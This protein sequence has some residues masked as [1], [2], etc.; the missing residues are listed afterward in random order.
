MDISALSAGTSFPIIRYFME[1]I[2]G[3]KG[4]SNLHVFVVHDPRLD[5]DIRSIPSDAPGYVH[6]FRGRSTLFDAS[7][8]AR[9]WLPQLATGR[10]GVLGRL[11]DFVEPH[12]TCPILPFPASDPRLEI[13]WAGGERQ[14]QRRVRRL[15]NFGRRRCL[16]LDLGLI[17]LPYKSTLP[18]SS[19]LWSYPVRPG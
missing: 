7:S 10:R 11:Y 4:P 8:A 3:G 14:A 2:S 19:Y 15:A 9:L 17:W 16:H 12:D 6:G 13:L 18:R 5:A 1:L